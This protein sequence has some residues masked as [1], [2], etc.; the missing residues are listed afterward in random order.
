MGIHGSLLASGG[1]EAH[2]DP[3]L[4]LFK[5]WPKSWDAAFTLRARGA[6]V[7]SSVQQDGKIPL[8]EIRSEAGSTCRLTNPWP[9]MNVTVYRD[10]TKSEEL[11]GSLLTIPTR[12]GEILVIVPENSEVSSI[13]IL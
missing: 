10:G 9:G 13:S 3:V 4:E 8:V 5:R 6:F 2:S 1:P 7:V 11:R 12:K